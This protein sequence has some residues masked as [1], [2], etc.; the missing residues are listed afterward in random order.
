M[1][2]YQKAMVVL[3]AVIA[4]VSGSIAAGVWLFSDDGAEV[5]LG[6]MTVSGS[7]AEPGVSL[8]EY[9]GTAT[10]VYTNGDDIEW[11]LRDAESTAYQRNPDGSYSERDFDDMVCHG[12]VLKVSDPG[13]YDVRLYANGHIARTGTLTLD[14]Y[15]EKEY[16]WTQVVSPGRSYTYSVNAR[17]LFSDYLGYADDRDAVRYGSDSLDDSRYIVTDGLE[18]LERALRAG[19]AD[20]RGSGALTDGQDYADYLLSFVQCCIA[21]PDTV[22]KTGRSVHADEDGSG[23]LFLYGVREYWAYPM[24]TIQR[25]YGD[26]EDT[27]FLA[28]ALFRLAGFESGVASIPYHMVAMVSLSDY[29]TNPFWETGFVLTSKSLTASG[30]NVFFCET[31]FEHFVPAGYLTQDAYLEIMKLQHID[32]EGMADA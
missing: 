20:V 26:C 8:D 12:P 4:A 25:G 19:Y 17:Y 16:E 5:V 6:D 28:A 31:T 1:E 32:V 11:R 14:G 15:V 3:V 9:A 24:E 13:R 18:D 29:A 21:Y 7:L 2:D 22:S 10:L 27:S 30:D 23:D